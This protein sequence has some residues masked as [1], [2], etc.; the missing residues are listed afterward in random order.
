[1]SKQKAILQLKEIER[2]SRGE[3][4]AAEEWQEDWKTLIAIVM[5]ARTTDKKTIPVAEQLFRKYRTVQSLA[6]ASPS[7]I[8]RIIRP[9]NFYRTKSRNIS[10]LSKILV[11][12]Y[13]GK[14]PHDFSKLIE[15]PGVGRKTANVFLASHGHSAIGAD[16]H[17]S[18]ISSQMGWT[19][20]SKQEKIEED[21]KKIFPEK[22]W[23]RVN[24]ILVR[25]GQ[26]YRSR[27]EK[28]RILEKIKL[29]K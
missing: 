26:T 6:K 2:L 4:L 15:L 29:L 25:F 1:M 22:Y 27:K 8:G 11:K 17:V 28:A 14:V 13:Q 24:E 21:L 18:W 5:S 9:V 7:D 12:K 16:T 20:S 23:G 19:K 3:R 10:S